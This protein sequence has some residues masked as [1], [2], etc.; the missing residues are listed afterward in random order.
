HSCKSDSRN[1]DSFRVSRQHVISTGLNRLHP[2]GC[3]R[4]GETVFELGWHLT[5]M[6][7]FMRFRYRLTATCG[8]LLRAK[9]ALRSSRT[10]A[11][12]TYLPLTSL[13]AKPLPLAATMTRSGIPLPAYFCNAGTFASLLYSIAG[14]GMP[15][16]RM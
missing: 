1:R 7:K 12:P 16:A 2:I 3:S 14:Q 9:I 15:L 5:K 11:G 4:P 13:A 8:E 6:P 10:L